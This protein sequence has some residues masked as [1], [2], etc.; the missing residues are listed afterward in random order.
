MSELAAILVAAGGLL[1]TLGGGVAFI[2]RKVEARFK[3][4]E[5]KLVEC[6]LREKAGQDRSVAHVTVIELL[7]Q[8]LERLSPDGSKVLVR[9]HQLLTDLKKPKEQREHGD[10]AA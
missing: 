9:A 1:T 5:A 8:E 2:W 6:E 7:W 10:G 3:S 4:I